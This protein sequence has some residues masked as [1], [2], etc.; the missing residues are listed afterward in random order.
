MIDFS[1]F[2]STRKNVLKF[3][4]KQ[5]KIISGMD[6]WRRWH[7]G[8]KL[9]E[10]ETKMFL[11][12]T[13][14]DIH[15]ELGTPFKS[16]DPEYDRF[17]KTQDEALKKQA[18]YYEDKFFN[19]LWAFAPKFIRRISAISGLRR[20][21]RE[22]VHTVNRLL[23][24]RFAF[25]DRKEKIA[26]DKEPKRLTEEQKTILKRIADKYLEPTKRLLKDPAIKF[27]QI[28]WDAFLNAIT[29][30]PEDEIEKPS[31]LI[32]EPVFQGTKTYFKIFDEDVYTLLEDS[33][34]PIKLIPR[35]Y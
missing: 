16:G 31:Y 19:L 9:S 1:R 15:G 13:N 30:L 11:Q 22:L 8:E 17:V 27:E 18:Q 12:I 20:K 2:L 5:K 26:Y 29:G 24:P 10:K 6:L 32:Y 4:E 3:A 35:K 14:P 28:L 34:L 33:G 25:E 23:S 21:L 7:R